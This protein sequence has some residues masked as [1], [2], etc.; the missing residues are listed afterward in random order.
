MNLGESYIFFSDLIFW[1]AKTRQVFLPKD[2][3]F[4]LFLAPEKLLLKYAYNLETN[5][6]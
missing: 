4:P 1:L 6:N 3:G 2:Q 5:Y